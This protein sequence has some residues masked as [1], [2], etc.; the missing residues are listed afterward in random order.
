MGAGACADPPEPLGAV[1]GSGASL[2]GWFIVAWSGRRCE[3]GFE[4]LAVNR[5]NFLVKVDISK[6][7]E[8]CNFISS[9]RR[10]MRPGEAVITSGSVGGLY[11]QAV[12][13]RTI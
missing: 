2:S 11:V 13:I 1:A 9:R 7:V 8:C 12:G 4:D 10:K 3:S 5:L 6:V